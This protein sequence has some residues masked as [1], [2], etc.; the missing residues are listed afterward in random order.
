MYLAIK[1]T[2]SLIIIAAFWSIPFTVLYILLNQ[3]GAEPAKF[4]PAVYFVFLIFSIS[5]KKYWSFQ[6]FRNKRKTLK[7]LLIFF[8]SVIF[9]MYL[10]SLI[11]RSHKLYDYLVAEK[12]NGWE[13][14]AHEADDTLGFKP[15]ANTKAYRTFSIGDK[16]PVFYNKNG[17]RVPLADINKEDTP[18][19]T[20]LLF[21]G[22]SYTFGDGCNA[23]ETF[24]YLVAKDTRLSCINAGVCS[25]GLSHM[26]I[27]AEKLIP[28][29]KPK[30]V[31]LQYSEWLA[32]RSISLYAP[33]YYT[34]LPTPYFIEKNN[35]YVLQ[36]PGFKSQS[37]NLDSREIK[38]FY[39]GKFIKFLFQKGLLFY[40]KEDWFYQINKISIITNKRLQP[41]NKIDEI[42]NYAYNK[43]KQIAE[44]NGSAV[45]IL[46]LGNIEY[47]KKSHQLFYNSNIKYAEAD[48]VLNNYLATSTTKD[49]AKEFNIWGFI[50]KD[51]IVVDAHPNS[52]AHR[53]IANSIIKVIPIRH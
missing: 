26:L 11:Y 37:F 36:Y 40:L 12:K 8:F 50:G 18:N 38:G 31:I 30:Y 35:S 19:K 9:C 52:K 17:F 5:H 29:Y 45:I 33:A 47:T 53:L 51:S 39:Q 2:V 28:K 10:N 46:N 7:F 48:S 24:P 23:E 4:I 16:I 1:K 44:A 22:C 3:I 20:D 14:I 49:F 41:S 15:V 13:G 6:T 27:L 42:E 43:I 34:Y 21:L 25:Y 32:A